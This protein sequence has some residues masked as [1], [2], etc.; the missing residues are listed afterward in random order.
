MWS[1]VKRSRLKLKQ[2]TPLHSIWMLILKLRFGVDTILLK[3]MK[4]FKVKVKWS[5]CGSQHYFTYRARLI[6][7]G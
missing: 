3:K 7:T 5:I 1:R 6:Q 4:V 2:S